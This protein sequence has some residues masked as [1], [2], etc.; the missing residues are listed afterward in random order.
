M[1]R[2]QK[3]FFYT[4]ATLILAFDL[5]ACSQNPSE[6]KDSSAVAGQS[7]AVKRSNYYTN[8]AKFI[9]GMMPDTSA[10]FNQLVKN[11]QWNNYSKSFD[12]TWARVEQKSLVK[13]RQWR[14]SDLAKINKETETLFYPFSGPDFLYAITF[15]PDAEK[16]ILFGLEKT[17]SAPDMKKLNSQ[18][19]NNYLASVNNSLEDI[20]KLSFFKTIEMSKELNNQE[21]DG[22]LPV[23][24]LF[25]ARTGNTIKSIKNADIGN[26]GKVSVADT[27]MAYKGP[28]RFNKGVEI[29]FSP[30]GKDSVNKKLYYFPEDF[31]DAPLS[32]N[33]GCKKYL[34]NIDSNVTTLLKSAS[35]LLHNQ[36]FS[37]IRNIILNK[38][39]Y[40][41]QDDSGIAFRFFE[42]SKWDFQLY[43]IYDKPID[44]F[45]YCYQKDL[46]EA[47]LKGAKSFNFKYGYGKGRNM[48]LAHKK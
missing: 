30:G 46:N 20:L 41:L 19:V 39:R 14:D 15:F 43:G 8:A 7:Q 38:S 23:I 27:F 9:A 44:V 42:K 1:M 37:F 24:M 12:T 17:G 21:V 2:I 10:P 6:K 35:Y 33:P 4:A 28:S 29:T 11:P 3:I 13:I 22:V 32:Q 31:T 36:I 5:T 26:D 18:N 25:M 47:Y 34:Q 48:L 45:S 16:Y 40:I